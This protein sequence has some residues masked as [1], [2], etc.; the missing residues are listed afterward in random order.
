MKTLFLALLIL[1]VLAMGQYAN[2]VA[3]GDSMTAGFY[4][5]G[6]TETYQRT[7][8]PALLAGQLGI[9]D[10]QLPLVSEPGI[11]VQL[12]LKKLSPLTIAPKDGAMGVPLNLYLPRPYNN[13]GVVGA[14]LSDCLSKKDDNGGMHSLVLRGIGSQVEQAIALQPDLIT[15]WI[16][17]NDALGAALMGTAVEGVTLTAKD[18]F[19]MQYGHLLDLLLS[20]TEADLVVANVPPVTANPF[21]TTIPPFIINPATGEVVINPATGQ[22]MTYLGQSDDG[23]PFI[24]PHAYVTLNAKQYL[25]Q[26]YGIPAALG[27]TGAPLPPTVVL[28]PNET[29]MIA[30]YIGSYNA[31]IADLAAVR[32][33]PVVDTFTLIAGWADH[34][35]E[36]AGIELNGD[37]LSGGLA[38]YDG[39]HPTPIAQALLANAFIETINA[40]YGRHIR[41]VGL[42]PF[43]SGDATAAAGAVDLQTMEL[44][45]WE[46]WMKLFTPEHWIVEGRRLQ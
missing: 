10:F 15:V 13:L 28:T 8:Y 30:D 6:L 11:P 16:G 41:L 39:F 1:P 45:G 40:A 12:E 37:F 23:S 21:V 27:G 42:Y 20:N 22:P 7:S 18:A 31:S 35:E 46:Y 26:G 38:G 9:A 44:R 25:L 34:G 17:A 24:S 36:F 19:Q 32:G 3:L 43:L 4:S 29:A 5:G 2:Y 33:V 14:N